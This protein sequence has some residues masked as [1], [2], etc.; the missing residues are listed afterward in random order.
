MAVDTA[1]L[2]AGL[3]FELGD[4]SLYVNREL[5]WLEFNDRVLQLARDPSIPL[6]ER[7]R[8][9]AITAANLDEFYMVRFATLKRQAAAGVTKRTPDGLTPAETLAAID[10]RAEPM[11]ATFNDLF[12]DELGPG[13]ERVGIAIVDYADLDADDRR[14]LRR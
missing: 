11:S 2:R 3:P 6:L 8:F 4:A 14:G 1:Q 12:V 13:L 5:S 10:A 9:L 7:T